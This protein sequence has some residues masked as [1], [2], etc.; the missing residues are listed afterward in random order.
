MVLCR[1]IPS[2]TRPRIEDKRG[3]DDGPSIV[4]A[5]FP[6]PIKAAAGLALLALGVAS[7][8][9]SYDEQSRTARGVIAAMVLYNLG[10]VFHP[11]GCWDPVAAGRHRPVAG[12]HP[13][14]N[15]GRLV[16]HESSS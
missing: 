2:E 5:I 1:I 6:R 7:W 10:A 13:S 14:R 12:R 4:S 9:A 16:R 3:W 15:D 8:L 11:S